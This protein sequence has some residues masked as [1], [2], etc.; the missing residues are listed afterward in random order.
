MGLHVQTLNE[1]VSRELSTIGTYI[2]VEA[3]IKTSSI[4]VGI[5]CLCTNSK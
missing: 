1:T 3:T 4:I 2:S 5:V